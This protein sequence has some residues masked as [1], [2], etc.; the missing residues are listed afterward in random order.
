[1]RRDLKP[2]DLASSSGIRGRVTRVERR[3]A[4]GFNVV[5]EIYVDWLIPSIANE[6]ASPEAHR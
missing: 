2:G 1:M 6:T 4:V 5:E 3:E